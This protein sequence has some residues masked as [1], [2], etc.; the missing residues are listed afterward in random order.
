VQ[1]LTP[2]FVLVKHKFMT[3]GNTDAECF[4]VAGAM[5]LKPV[6][7]ESDHETHRTAELKQSIAKGS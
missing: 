1:T 6:G 2:G 3:G 5:G 4:D 7:R